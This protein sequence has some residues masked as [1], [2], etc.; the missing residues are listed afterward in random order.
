[1]SVNAKT[2]REDVRRIKD[3]RSSQRQQRRLFPDGHI[4]RVK[5]VTQEAARVLVMLRG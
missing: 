1:M 2:V 3:E 5:L 4:D